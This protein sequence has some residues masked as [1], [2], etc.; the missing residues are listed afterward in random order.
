[1]VLSWGMRKRG[2]LGAGLSCGWDKERNIDLSLGYY[3]IH[4]IIS[5]RYNINNKFQ[6]HK[7]NPFLLNNDYLFIITQYVLLKDSL[8]FSG[9]LK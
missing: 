4:C 1:M 6:L 3:R 9:L 7:P 8:L 2:C 5:H